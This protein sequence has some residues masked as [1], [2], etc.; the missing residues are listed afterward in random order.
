[1]DKEHY[2]DPVMLSQE[3]YDQATDYGPEYYDPTSGF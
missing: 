2:N 3:V 1:M